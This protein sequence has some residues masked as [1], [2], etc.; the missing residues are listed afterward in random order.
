VGPNGVKGVNG[1]PPLLLPSVGAG[2]GFCVGEG[3]GFAVGPGVGCF[4]GSSVGFCVGA[5]VG[6][7][8]GAPVVGRLLGMTDG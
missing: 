4:V 6:F 5:P 1:T 7:L 3:L 8:V 2:D